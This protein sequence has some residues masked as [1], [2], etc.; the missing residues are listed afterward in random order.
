VLRLAA[1]LSHIISLFLI[2]LPLSR[3]SPSYPKLFFSSQS[4]WND[5]NNVFNNVRT[6]S[7]FT[8]GSSPGITVNHIWTNGSSEPRLQGATNNQLKNADGKCVDPVFHLNLGLSST[9]PWPAEAAAI[10][11]NAGRRSGT[12]PVPVVLPLSPP[13]PAHADTVGCIHFGL[14]PCAENKPSQRFLLSPGECGLHQVQSLVI[15]LDP[16]IYRFLSFALCT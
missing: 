11:N 3:S 4:L 2:T 13:V 1:P 15:S 9:D 12:L 8:H 14:L 10:I 6:P 7:V 16:Y 5:E